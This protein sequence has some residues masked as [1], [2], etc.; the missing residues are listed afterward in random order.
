VWTSPISFV[1]SANC[2]R[3]CGAS[4]DFV[5]IDAA[6]RNIS[7]AALERKLAAAERAGTLPDLLVPVDFSGMPCDLRELRALADRYK[8]RILEDASHAVGAQYAGQPLGAQYADI[9][10]FSFHP[11]KIIT[12]AEGGMLTTRSDELAATLRE[13]RTHGITREAARMVGESHGPWYYEQTTLGY[14]YRMTDMQAALGTSQLQRIGQ[15][16]ARRLHLV[17]RYDELLAKLP[18]LTL[19]VPPDRVSSWHLYVVEIDESRCN[20]SRA[21]VYAKLREAGI[22]PNVHYIPIHLQPYYRELG[23]ERGAFPVAERYYS[24]ALTIPLF[25]DMTEAQ[26]DH[27]VATLAAALKS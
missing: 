18:L 8:F 20:V 12:T 14:N 27:V 23:F 24:R 4:V 25:P 5:D 21:T 11:V 9:T 13:L 19:R 3:Y 22:A 10:V 7:V 26:Q 17:R 6:T 15:F 16:H 1:A 2:A